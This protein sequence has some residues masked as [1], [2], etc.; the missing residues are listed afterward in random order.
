[1]FANCWQLLSGSDE[2]VL[3]YYLST[4]VFTE[5]CSA[6]AETFCN[7]NK[8]DG[9]TDRQLIINNGKCE[10]YVCQPVSKSLI[11]IRVVIHDN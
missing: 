9:R 3:E 1:M 11:C 10:S 5:P 4:R 7:R 6:Y 2:Y 8:T